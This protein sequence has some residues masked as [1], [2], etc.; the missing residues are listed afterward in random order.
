MLK[1]FCAENMEHVE[2]AMKQGVQRIELCDNLAVGGT[3]PSYG[4]IKQAVEVGNRY[5]VEISTMIRPRGGNFHYSKEE[6]EIMKEDIQQ[7][8]GLGTSGVVF[9]CLTS[10]LTIDK[11]AMTDLLDICKGIEVTFHMA[12][13]HIKQQNQLREMDWLIEQGVTRILTHG[14]LSGTVLENKEWLNQTI[15]HTDDQI[16]ILVGGGV[17][18]ENVEEISRLINTNQFHGTKIVSFRGF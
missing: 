3:T 5:G 18:F 4:V 16:E 10:D 2:E 8:K 7:A 12:Y 14:G 1:E 13:D 11:E 15:A 17:T 6:I 9:G